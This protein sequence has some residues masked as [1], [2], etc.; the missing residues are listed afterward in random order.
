MAAEQITFS[1]GSN[2]NGDGFNKA[3]NAV[4]A[5]G[6]FANA[7]KGVFTEVISQIQSTDGEVGKLA[8]Q[9]SQLAIIAGQLGVAG[10]AMY[11][12]QQGAQALGDYIAHMNDDLLHAVEH[13]N[14]LSERLKKIADTKVI[15]LMKG[16]L[17]E[18]TTQGNALMASIKDSADAL[19]AL[20]GAKSESAVARMNEQIAGMIK[21]KA[22]AVAGA[23]GEFEKQLAG[24]NA[25]IKIAQAE[26]EAA[27]AQA[28]GAVEKAGRDVETATKRQLQ[29]ID[30]VVSA[31][32]AVELAENEYKKAMLHGNV[33]LAE[34]QRDVK[35]SRAALLAAEKAKEKADNDLAVAIEKQETATSNMNAKMAQ[36]ET[37]IIQLTASRDEL[38]SKHNE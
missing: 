10:A 5:T 23:L 25:D 30:N 31:Q 4:K 35:A 32:R 13:A 38:I 8:G 12:V 28:A 2:F 21:E 24:A 14:D 6:K 36:A 33:S 27:H 11:G 20:A 17:E 1:I 22:Q 16:A 3:N 37:K 34:Y 19:N 15:A 26:L 29:A 9:F 18:A 7:A